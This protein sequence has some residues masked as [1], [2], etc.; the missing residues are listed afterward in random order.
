[1]LSLLHQ[2]FVISAVNSEAESCNSYNIQPALLIMFKPPFSVFQFIVFFFP[3]LVQFSDIV[4]PAALS[5]HSSLLS[6]VLSSSS[7][8]MLK[9]FSSQSY[10][11][12]LYYCY[13]MPKKGF[14]IGLNTIIMPNQVRLN[15]HLEKY[16]SLK[17]LLMIT[18]T[19]SIKQS[20]N[21]GR[22]PC[23]SKPRWDV[24]LYNQN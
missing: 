15:C 16:L 8:E 5:S 21:A 20:Q 23:N 18:A 13:R 14:Q 7:R 11:V 10:F 2:Y 6:S 12:K 1:M 3:F 9:A 24:S 17:E 22:W 19:I 4:V